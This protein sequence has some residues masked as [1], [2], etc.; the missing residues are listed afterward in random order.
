MPNKYPVT[1]ASNIREGDMQ[2]FDVNQQRII[3]AHI[4][5]KYHAFDE[6]CSHEEYPLL[7]GALRADHVECPLHGSRFCLRTGQPM[8]EPAT[9]PIKVYPVEIIDGTV[10]VEV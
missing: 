10:Y 9:A 8:E 2:C 1:P 7:N 6:M 5:G 4:A 3:V